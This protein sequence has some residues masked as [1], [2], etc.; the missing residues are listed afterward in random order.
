MSKGKEIVVPS[1][2][3]TRVIVP[4][5]ED[6]L[7]FSGEADRAQLGTSFPYLRIAYP[8]SQDK[9]D[10][11]PSGVFY[12]SITGA[13]YGKSVTVMLLDGKGGRNQWPKPWNKDNK[14]ICASDDGEAPS[15]R[16]TDP[17]P[18]PCLKRS[19]RSGTLVPSCPDAMW[20]G[21]QPPVCNYVPVM[22]LWLVEQMMPVIYSQA[23]NRGLKGVS[24]LT[25][26]YQ[27]LAL[28][29]NPEAPGVSVR[30][31]RPARMSLI[32]HGTY[33]TADFQV[34]DEMVPANLSIELHEMLPQLKAIFRA[35]RIEETMGSSE[36]EGDTSFDT[37]RM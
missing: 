33:W 9:P 34:L 11:C 5:P 27:A 35:V 32:D 21:N 13:I 22:L 20:V 7:P 1:Q 36:D 6:D 3:E 17:R 19:S 29:G 10:G 16:G 23:K 28:N 8:G 14:P 12:N 37:E 18:G 4:P 31:V 30:L 26:A 2:E 15:G 24:K 25:S